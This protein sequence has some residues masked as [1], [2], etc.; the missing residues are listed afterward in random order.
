M[1]E[2]PTLTVR[3]MTRRWGSCTKSGTV[4]LN[5]DLIKV[6]LTFIDYVIVHE[7]CHLKVHNHS[8]AFYR[9][10][11]RSMPDWKQRKERLDSF[12]I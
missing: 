12:A 5:I 9:L 6:P 11:F 1:P 2:M 10:L 3:K 8:P 4:A 7:L